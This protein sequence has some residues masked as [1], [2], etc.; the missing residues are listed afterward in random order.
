MK[1]AWPT[2]KFKID[3]FVSFGSTFDLTATVYCVFPMMLDSAENKT[4]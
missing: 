4:D 2:L 1:E 3:L